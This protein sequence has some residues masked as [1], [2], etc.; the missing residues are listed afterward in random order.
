MLPHAESLTLN[1]ITEHIKKTIGDLSAF[2]HVR[3]VFTD[4]KASEC[5]E[6][7]Q[8]ETR[9]I[10]RLYWVSRFTDQTL[11]CLIF[12]VSGRLSIASSEMMCRI[13][14]DGIQ[15][16]K[17]FRAPKWGK[18]GDWN[19][20]KCCVIGVLFLP[21]LC[22]QPI[23]NAPVG[24]KYVRCPCNCLLICKVTS[25]RIACP[26]PYW[27]DRETVG[28]FFTHVSSGLLSHHLCRRG[29]SAK[30]SHGRDG[31]EKLLLFWNHSTCT[32]GLRSSF[33]IYIYF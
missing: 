16:E 25:Q 9:S 1:C 11:K 30:H 12:P 26:R 7:L 2:Y 15:I 10:R 21:P 14:A 18:P 27:W 19:L 17:Y 5:W 22:L 29:R 13:S 3:N 8:S 24:K 32:A 23:K 6:W 33:N 28:L 4:L 31:A 20:K